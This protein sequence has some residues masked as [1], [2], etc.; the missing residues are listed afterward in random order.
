M[1]MKD[2]LTIGKLA[3]ACGV[4]VET[5]RFYER[6]GLIEQPPK[7]GG[8]RYYPQNY[9]IRVDFIKKSK[10]LGFTLCEIQELLNL[11]VDTKSSC[12]DVLKRTELKINEIN[13]KIKDLKKMKK[14]LEALADCCEDRNLSLSECPILE[15]F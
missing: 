3:K 4:S 12:G 1:V 7:A 5:I 15:C 8:F 13:S 9:I 14:S 6:K 10:N 2:L 11:K